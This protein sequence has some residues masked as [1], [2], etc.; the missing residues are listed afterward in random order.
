MTKYMREHTEY[1][2]SKIE[3]VEINNELLK[4]HKEQIE[5]LKHERLAHLIVM[6]LFAVLLIV[7][8]AIL[9]LSPAL[10]VLLLC[11]ILA[12]MEA[13]YVVH[14]YRLENTVQKWYRIGNQIKFLLDG[15]GVNLL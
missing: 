5:H 3:Q 12:I 11:G 15:V 7:A 14:Y 4:Y 10:P 13:F 8:F 2:L 1:M 6:C 9:V